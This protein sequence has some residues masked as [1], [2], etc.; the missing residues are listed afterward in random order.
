M[1]Y[2]VEELARLAGVRIDTVRYYQSRGLLPPPRR[3]GRVAWYGD[4]HLE[5]LRRIRGLR[6]EGLSLDWIGRML[7][8]PPGSSADPAPDSASSTLR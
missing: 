5:R 2:R 3:E 7:D 4:P 1:E 8:G 6:E